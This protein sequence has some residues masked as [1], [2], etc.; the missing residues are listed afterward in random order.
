MYQG[1]KE[2]TLLRA[3]DKKAGSKDRKRK[4]TT[5]NKKRKVWST[6]SPVFRKK[7]LPFIQDL[8][9]KLTGHD[10]GIPNISVDILP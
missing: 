8:K 6:A 4:V 10:Q 3:P 9:K 5:R 1:Q 7:F 2:R